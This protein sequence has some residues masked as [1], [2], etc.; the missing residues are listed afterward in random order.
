MR[1]DST[2]AAF[3]RV[4]FSVQP[5]GSKQEAYSF[6]L[7]TSWPAPEVIAGLNGRIQSG[8]RDVR[9]E[10]HGAGQRP[11]VVYLVS[12]LLVLGAIGNPFLLSLYL[13]IPLN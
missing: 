10:L 11:S 5:V 7:F 12:G 1:S 13:S 6:L 9:S 3:L 2:D 8:R 4:T